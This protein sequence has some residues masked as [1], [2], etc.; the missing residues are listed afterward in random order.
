MTA[1]GGH[2][3]AI[4][5]VRRELDF[6]LVS[7]GEPD[8]W[9]YAQYHCGTA[10]NVYFN[11]HW[12]FFVPPSAMLVDKE[13][14]VLVPEFVRFIEHTVPSADAVRVLGDQL[15][16]RHTA[17]RGL[18]PIVS[19]EEIVE[20]FFRCHV[21]DYLQQEFGIVA[22]DVPRC[23]NSSHRA[24]RRVCALPAAHSHAAI[25]DS[26]WQS[27]WL[28]LQQLYPKVNIRTARSERAKRADLYVLARNEIISFEFKHVGQQ[29]FGQIPGCAAQVS[30]YI[31]A[32][33]AAAILVVYSS[34]HQGHTAAL[35]RLRGLLGD[36]VQ[37]ACATG[38]AIS[39]RK[40]GD[41]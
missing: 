16:S 27:G 37:L 26:E 7:K 31:A 3:E 10:S 21:I 18:K 32:G 22:G 40:P 33:H 41:G 30:R 1:D 12:S 6:Y 20:S 36:G 23:I 25:Q 24:T 35:A 5:D 17:L 13:P 14:A 29:G 4:D 28:E 2:T 34:D 8:P 11:V 15:L 9:V 38:P 39:V 19:A